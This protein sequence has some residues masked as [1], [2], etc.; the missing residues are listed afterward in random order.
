MRPRPVGVI[1][2]A[3][4]VAF[5]RS[6]NGQTGLCKESDNL[7]ELKLV[8]IGINRVLVEQAGQMKE[9]MIFEGYGGKSLLPEKGKN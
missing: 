9:L 1:G 5:L 7:D 2:I 4:N 8:K 3:G 6:A